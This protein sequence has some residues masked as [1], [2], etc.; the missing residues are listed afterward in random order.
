MKYANII[1][2]LPFNNA[3]SYEIPIEIKKSVQV[4]VRVL[5]PFGKRILTGFVTELTDHPEVTKGIKKIIDVL[6]DS[7]LFD[8]DSLK[9]FE[10]LAEYYLCSTGEALK[11][12]APYGTEL[13]SKRR[14]SADQDFCQQ[15]LAEEK[16]QTSSRYKI[17]RVL[18]NTP[19][20]TILALQKETRTKNIYST[21]QSLR[22]KGAITIH[23]EI[24]PPK[25]SIKTEKAVSL[26]MSPDEILELIPELER[27]APKQ[28]VIL[29]YIFSAQETEISAKS[30]LD[31]TSAGYATLNSLADKGFIRIFDKEIERKFLE[32]FSEIQ[33][34][35][36][37]T[38][39]QK[40]AIESV[41]GSI[42]QNEFKAFLLHGV[43]GSGKTQVYLELA[44]RAIENGKNALILVPEISLTP[45][46]T[47]RFINR[48][49]DIVAV[50]HSGM[51]LGERYDS[52]RGILSGKYRIVIGARSALFSPLK[53]P[54]IVIVDEE[55][56]HSY[57][58]FENIPRYQARDCA[59]ALANFNSC[60]VV[61]GSATP[62]V[63][64]LYNVEI[65]KYQLLSLT[66][67][68]DDA[69]MPTI[70]LVTLKY[71]KS[72]KKQDSFISNELL[73]AIKTRILR[74]EGVIILQNRRGFAT[75]IYCQDCGEIV[76]CHNCS[77]SMVLHLNMNHLKCHYCG[78]TQKTPKACSV[79][80]SLNLR[81]FGAGTQKVEDELE[82]HIPEA[83]IARVDSDSIEGRGKL[84]RILTDF[85][86]GALDILVGTQ[87]VSKGLD[88]DHVT[89][90]GV[91]SAE[92][93]LW[94]PD[95]RAEERTFQLLTQVSGRAGRS[96]NPGIVIIQTYNQEHFV[97]QKVLR[98]DFAGFSKRELA[99]RAEGGYPPFTRLC[100]IEIKDEDQKK[101]L[102]A[103]N[104]FYKFLQPF[105][106]SVIIT[107]PSPAVI[108]KLKN[109]F[110]FQILVKSER[111]NDASGKILRNAVREAFIRFNRESR[112]KDIRLVIDI[113]PYSMM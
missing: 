107:P 63:E 5:V 58:Q 29:L 74:K 23:N 32:T 17:L 64:S 96:K 27:K 111:K 21:L 38:I 97:L 57:K 86:D 41:S 66:E 62:S 73:D 61:L 20:I 88:F 42:S 3:F 95:F 79:C 37:P 60:P 98:H 65:G 19:T 99:L 52:W 78:E 44:A 108:D 28:A 7:P 103:I 22:E 13:E 11:N 10:W 16:K 45:Q 48:F 113:D 82:Y 39:Q 35:I 112:F 93:T 25:V 76:Q 59:V 92:S 106:N 69:Q 87:M 15:L 40:I 9:F 75:Q 31:K 102:G 47:S 56:D 83:R 24:E 51:S 14:I 1:F 36:S 55:H 94:F 109:Y 80:G 54:G 12:I 100:L 110:R 30:V 33:K 46:I 71:E 81:Y 8:R 72:G 49:G 85:R 91:I 2:P 43:T 104:D 53:N 90:V 101:S 50:L 84:S 18:S 89:L 105:A 4:G 26:L 70:N 34:D 6:D 68:I 77:V 67:R